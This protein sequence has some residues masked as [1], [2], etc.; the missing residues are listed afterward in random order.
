MTTLGPALL[1]NLGDHHPRHLR[2]RIREGAKPRQ[3]GAGQTFFSLDLNGQGQTSMMFNQHV[4]FD[5]DAPSL[6]RKMR[7][8]WR[9]GHGTDRRANS[10]T[11]YICRGWL[12]PRFQNLP[13][14]RCGM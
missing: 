4:H 12:N 6:I 14:R 5:S 2:M 10:L 9:K 11:S 3:I 1:R 8:I 13:P 7:S